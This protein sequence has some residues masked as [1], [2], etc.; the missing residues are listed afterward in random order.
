M[1]TPAYKLA[2][3][4]PEK[5]HKSELKSIFKRELEHEVY[6]RLVHFVWVK[7]FKQHIPGTYSMYIMYKG[8]IAIATNALCINE[9]LDAHNLPRRK[10]LNETTVK[11]KLLFNRLD[12]IQR[13][14]NRSSEFGYQ[15]AKPGRKRGVNIERSKH[16][17]AVARQIWELYQ[18]GHNPGDIAIAIG[19][20]PANVYYHIKRYQK[21]LD[22]N[23]D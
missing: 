1:T 13:I 5:I 12:D 19:C 7:K 15:K 22:K 21:I 14:D 18:E 23:K 3:T 4:E 16:G 8:G 11:R 10:P 2:E 17:T 9:W 20:T 6:Q